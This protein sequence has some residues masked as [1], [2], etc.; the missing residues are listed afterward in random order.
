MTKFVLNQIETQLFL[1]QLLPPVI[2]FYFLSHLCY[3]GICI[4]FSPPV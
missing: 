3:E 4:D 2:L 1:K